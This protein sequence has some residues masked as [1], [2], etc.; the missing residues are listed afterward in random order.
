MTSI[1]RQISDVSHLNIKCGDCGK[2]IQE[3]P[4]QPSMDRPLYCRDCDANNRTAGP[5]SGSG[6]RGSRF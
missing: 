6:F 1:R 5:R 2:Q 3:S 4:S